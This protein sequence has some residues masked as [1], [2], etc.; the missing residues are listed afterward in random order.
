MRIKNEKLED[1]HNIRLDTLK[2]YSVFYKIMNLPEGVHNRL[3]NIVLDFDADETAV[4]ESFEEL[5]A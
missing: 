1:V 3:R 4:F 2:P 5:L